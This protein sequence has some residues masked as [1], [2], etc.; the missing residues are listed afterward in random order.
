MPLAAANSTCRGATRGCDAGASCTLMQRALPKSAIRQCCSRPTWSCRAAAPGPSESTSSAAAASAAA[1][2]AAGE[3][4]PPGVVLEANLQQQQQQLETCAQHDES[5]TDGAISEIGS[6]ISSVTGSRNG[7]SVDRMSIGLLY[8][9]DDSKSIG[10]DCPSSTSSIERSDS[11]NVYGADAQPNQREFEAAQSSAAAIEEQI[12]QPIVSY[13]SFS[14][15]DD[16]VSTYELEAAKQAAKQKEAAIAAAAGAA[17]ATTDKP[18]W[19]PTEFAALLGLAV[20]FV[21]AGISNALQCKPVQL[22]YRCVGAQHPTACLGCNAPTFCLYPKHVMLARFLYQLAATA[23]AWSTLSHAFTALHVLLFKRAA[24]SA[25]CGSAA[26]AAA[27]RQ[28]R[29]H[30]TSTSCGSRSCRCQ[31]CRCR[32]GSSWTLMR[33]RPPATGCRCWCRCRQQQMMAS[34]PRCWLPR[35]G[36]M[37]GAAAGAARAGHILASPCACNETNGPAF[38]CVDQAARM[39]SKCACFVRKSEGPCVRSC[40]LVTLICNQSTPLLLTALVVSAVEAELAQLALQYLT[41]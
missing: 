4:A 39:L 31:R 10:S 32:C 27:R 5:N 34:A 12:V 18:W 14:S 38:S 16:E 40:R 15:I 13:S 8:T 37:A 19:P 26:A 35:T 1:A 21:I 28:C 29:Q 33:C 24:T 30:T 6:S 41:T 2:T 20:A 25:S 23:A 17:A 36:C 9:E 7:S 3:A 11:S 22:N